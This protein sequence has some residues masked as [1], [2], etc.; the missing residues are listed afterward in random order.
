M[1]IE[2]NLSNFFNEKMNIYNYYFDF[3]MQFHLNVTEYLKKSKN[4]SKN[5]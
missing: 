1:L 2:V 5:I 4:R 3:L